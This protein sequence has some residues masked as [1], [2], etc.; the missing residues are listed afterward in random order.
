M[1]KNAEKLLRRM[2]SPNADIRYTAIEA[3]NDTYWTE[4]PACRIPDYSTSKQANPITDPA[5]VEAENQNADE[6][7][8]LAERTNNLVSPMKT[9]PKLPSKD[10]KHI[11][12]RQDLK[13]RT[14]KQT[15]FSE[16]ISYFTRP[17]L[18]IS[19][20]LFLQNVM[21]DNLLLK[22][23]FYPPSW[24]H[25]LH[26]HQ[27]RRRT[28]LILRFPCHEMPRQKARERI[29][30]SLCLRFVIR[31]SRKRKRRHPRTRM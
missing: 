15:S 27:H 17:F 16:G 11:I 5:E 31:L 19:L 14:S 29:I 8:V 12:D 18:R 25:P 28:F 24:L 9:P 7:K 26:F 23:P 20:P 3:M 4:T 10:F 2:I 13:R 22:L 21:L 1:S 6:S 30:G